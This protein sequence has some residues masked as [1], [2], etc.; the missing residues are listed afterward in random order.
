MSNN[1][2]V[3]TIRSHNLLKVVNQ[4]WDLHLFEAITKYEFPWLSSLIGK[5][6]CTKFELL[7]D[8]DLR[9]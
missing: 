3:L 2:P 4:R 9:V 1:F 5:S 6:V 8:F 7:S